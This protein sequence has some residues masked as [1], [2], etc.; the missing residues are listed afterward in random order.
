M[1]Y[2]GENCLMPLISQDQA[3]MCL[4]SKNLTFLGDSTVQ[5]FAKE[6]VKFAGEYPEEVNKEFNFIPLNPP[7]MEGCPRRTRFFTRQINDSARIT[8]CWNVASDPC[9]DG[10]SMTL[11]EIK[12]F[13]DRLDAC[14]GYPDQVAHFPTSLDE[15]Q[16]VPQGTPIIPDSLYWNIGLHEIF[17]YDHVARRKG[18]FG[19]YFI[20]GSKN[21]KES[22]YVDDYKNLDTYRSHVK[23]LSDYTRNLKAKRYYYQSTL[24]KIGKPSWVVRYFNRLA[25]PVV[26][27]KGFTWLPIHDLAVSRSDRRGIPWMG[28]VHHM[29]KDGQLRTPH[30]YYAVQI[31][32]NSMCG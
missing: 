12:G 10:Q 23:A 14:V 24:P 20:G 8:F 32:L 4:R 1:A 15:V 29:A 7:A 22:K 25:L 3:K 13:R 18:R 28:T 5:E 2:V 17:S 9:Q 19:S 16:Y 31:Y 6:L 26:K 21:Y 30:L 11:L 27:E